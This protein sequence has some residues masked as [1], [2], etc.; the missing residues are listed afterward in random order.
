MVIHSAIELLFLVL[1]V[2][3]FTLSGVKTPCL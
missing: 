3:L 1:Q 2:G